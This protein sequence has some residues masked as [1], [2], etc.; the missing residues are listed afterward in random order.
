MV[1]SQR[2]PK[3]YRPTRPKQWT[4][5]TVWWSATVHGDPDT[6][7]TDFY[8]RYLKFRFPKKNGQIICDRKSQ[9]DRKFELEAIKWAISTGGTLTVKLF[10]LGMRIFFKAE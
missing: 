3:R 2:P 9:A 10:L 8:R 7:I 4:I 6:V 5:R 1:P